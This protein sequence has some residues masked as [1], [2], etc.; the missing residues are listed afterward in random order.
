MI[1]STLTSITVRIIAVL[2]LLVYPL[3]STADQNDPALNGLFERLAVT[4]SDEEASNITREIWQRWTA[5]DDPNISQ[6]MQ[7]GIRGLS[8][9]SYRLSLIHI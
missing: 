5:I 8:Y 7:I 2:V 6:L 3:V 9:S 1:I 4:T